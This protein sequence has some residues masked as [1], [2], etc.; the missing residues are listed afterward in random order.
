MTD[1]AV[2]HIGA[3]TCTSGLRFPHLSNEVA[4]LGHCGFLSFLVST[5]CPMRPAG[6]EPSTWLITC[7]AS[8]GAWGPCS[9]HLK[10]ECSL[11][12]TP[13][14]H[15]LLLSPAE[16]SPLGRPGL[17]YLRT[18]PPPSQSSRSLCRRESRGSQAYPMQSGP[19]SLGPCPL[20]LAS[21]LPRGRA[22][23]CQESP[24]GKAKAEEVE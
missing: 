17:F 3:V 8:V 4:G 23:W 12:E 7:T 24:G 1:V 13:G 11:L 20:Q 6:W 5:S 19:R 21:Y 15:P 18:V 9:P 14:R 2:T 16:A 22:V 10:G